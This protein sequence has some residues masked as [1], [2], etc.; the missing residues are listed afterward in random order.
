MPGRS[1]GPTLRGGSA[2][3]SSGSRWRGVGSQS[4][5]LGRSGEIEVKG[6]GAYQ[7]RWADIG[8][9]GFCGFGP[10]AG[11]G[12]LHATRR[13]EKAWVWPGE[14]CGRSGGDLWDKGGGG[15][16]EGSPAAAGQ[17]T[18]PI[19]FLGSARIGK[20]SCFLGYTDRNESRGG[21]LCRTEGRG[22]CS[23]EWLSAYPLR[24][25]LT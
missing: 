6:S 21:W 23:G 13:V 3:A 25:W 22:H 17:R 20:F 24:Y 9:F 8:G 2:G 7:E 18:E 1:I 14:S 4:G 15:F 5:W 12:D 16:R 10:C 11:G 19:L